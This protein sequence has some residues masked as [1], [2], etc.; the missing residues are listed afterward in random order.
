[1]ITLQILL[2]VSL[3]YPTY[4][5]LTHGMDGLIKLDIQD[6]RD[7]FFIFILGVLGCVFFVCQIIRICIMYLP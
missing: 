6:G 2:A 3:L 5:L 4:M 7:R 1:M